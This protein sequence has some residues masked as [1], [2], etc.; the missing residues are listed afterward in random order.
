MSDFGKEN[1]GKEKKEV[2]GEQNFFEENR[3]YDMPITVVYDDESEDTGKRLDVFL[4]EFM[5][6]DYL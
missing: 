1:F 2:S 4:A 3:A 5:I 6:I